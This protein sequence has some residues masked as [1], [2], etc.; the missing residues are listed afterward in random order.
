MFCF[1][2]LGIRLWLI[3]IMKINISLAVNGIIYV[4]ILV[5]EGVSTYVVDFNTDVWDAADRILIFPV[6]SGEIYRVRTEKAVT[7]GLSDVRN[8]SVGWG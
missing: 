3:F 1:Y 4:L 7:S 2:F 5:V 6:L 8:W